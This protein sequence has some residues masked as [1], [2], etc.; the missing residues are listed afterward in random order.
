MNN[1]TISVQ[2][3]LRR[4]QGE[5]QAFSLVRRPSMQLLGVV[6]IVSGCYRTAGSSLTLNDLLPFLTSLNPHTDICATHCLV[7]VRL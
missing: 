4:G 5:E 6:C 2:F 7:T 3:I 1:F